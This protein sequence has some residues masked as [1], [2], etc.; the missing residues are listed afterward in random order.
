MSRE[1]QATDVLVLLSEGSCARDVARAANKFAGHRRNDFEVLAAFHAHTAFDVPA[2]SRLRRREN[3]LRGLAAVLALA[4]ANE[5]L[6]AEGFLE[7]QFA[8]ARAIAQGRYADAVLRLDEW[9]LEHGYRKAEPDRR[10]I[11]WDISDAS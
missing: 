5:K 11:A 4:G 8:E 9:L 6:L 2:R 1:V 10:P 3:E 7:G